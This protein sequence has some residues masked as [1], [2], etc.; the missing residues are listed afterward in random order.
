MCICSYYDRIVFRSNTGSRPCSTAMTTSDIVR[1][2]LFKTDLC[3]SYFAGG[4]AQRDCSFAHAAEEL[5][6]RP[7][8][9]KTAY[10]RAHREGK[11]T[12]GAECS[13][14]H[15]LREMRCSEGIYK[16]QLC[17]NFE[18]KGFCRKGKNCRHAHGM[19]E[20]RACA[21]AV[22]YKCSG[23]KWYYLV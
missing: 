10:C 22:P 18:K 19:S 4:C 13:F 7:V 6:P 1:K 11:C 14:A 8:L 9:Q 3:R 17:F 12:L 5:R 2:A 23:D 16:T 15:T 20:L 21:F